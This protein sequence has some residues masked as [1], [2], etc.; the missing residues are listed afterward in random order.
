MGNLTSHSLISVIM[1]VYNGEPYLTE[2]IDSVLGQTYQSLE[3]IIILDSRSTDRSEE[4][5]RSYPSNVACY[6]QKSVGLSAARNDG[7]DLA[8]GEFFA[9]LDCDDIWML[10]KLE[11][12]MAAFARDPELDMVFGHV[13]QFYSPEIEDEVRKKWTYAAEIMP[14]HIASA[15]LVRRESFF[16]VGLFEPK[17]HFGDFI[18]WYPRAVE[19]GLKGHMLSEILFRRRIHFNNIGIREREHQSDY[20]YAIKSLLDRRRKAQSNQK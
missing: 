5:A 8:R 9:F 2:A 1:P 15:I 16:R 11:L 18:D 19:R 20:V 3:L 4:I 13:R 10:N 14:A 12:Q 17:L 7:I 6:I